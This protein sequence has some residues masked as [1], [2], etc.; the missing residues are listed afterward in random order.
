MNLDLRLN[1]RLNLLAG[2]I[3]LN[4]SCGSIRDYADDCFDSGR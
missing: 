2:R 1:L 4:N 3:E